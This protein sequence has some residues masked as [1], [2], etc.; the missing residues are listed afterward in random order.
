MSDDPLYRDRDFDTLEARCSKDTDPEVKLALMESSPA[1]LRAWC[2]KFPKKMHRAHDWLAYTEENLRY[3][4][5][6]DREIDRYRHK[7][8]WVL[9]LTVSTYAVVL[10]LLGAWL[11]SDFSP[12]SRSGNSSPTKQTEQRGGHEPTA[13]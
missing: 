7:Q 5:T 12:F 9:T 2:R 10:G 6:I 8:M 13:E 4:D 1:R 3:R 11:L